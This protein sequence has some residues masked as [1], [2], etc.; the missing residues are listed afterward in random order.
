MR[1]AETPKKG[2]AF[3]SKVNPYECP[4]EVYVEEGKQIED[5]YDEITEAEYNAIQA[6]IE[7]KAREEMGM[8]IDG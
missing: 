2:F 4:F 7:A 6:E 5:L 8:V 3:R 1:K